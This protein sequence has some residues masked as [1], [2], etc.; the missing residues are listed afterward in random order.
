MFMALIPRLGILILI[1]A[2]MAGCSE[3]Q[4][5]TKENIVLATM[6]DNG[7]TLNVDIDVCAHDFKADVEETANE[8]VITAKAKGLQMASC[9]VVASVTLKEPLGNRDLIDAYDDESIPIVDS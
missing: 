9:A 4:S 2:I 3:S 7:R 5:Y 8:V 6:S 1:S